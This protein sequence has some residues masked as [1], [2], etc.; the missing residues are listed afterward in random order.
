ML[1]VGV[2]LGSVGEFGELIGSSLPRSS[3][4][5]FC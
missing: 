2:I 4:S 3:R 1:Q 5:C